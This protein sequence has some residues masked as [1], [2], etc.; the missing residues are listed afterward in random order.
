MLGSRR[1]GLLALSLL[2]AGACGGPQ[3]PAAP[4]TPALLAASFEDLVKITKPAGKPL[5][6]NHW[7]T[8]CGP[9]VD[10]L[11]Y[12]AEVAKRFEGKATFLGVSWDITKRNQA[13]G[14]TLLAVD[15]VRAEKG[16]YYPTVVAPF[17]IEELANTLSLDAQFIPQTYVFAPDGTRLWAFTGEIIEADDKAAFEAAIAKAAAHQ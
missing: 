6:V 2:S 11:P 9:C 16:S 4:Q 12:L 3:A 1:A 13:T 5:I 10:E 17:G 15:R 14:P 7:A 8:W